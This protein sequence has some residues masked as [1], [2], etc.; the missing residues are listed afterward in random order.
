MYVIKYRANKGTVDIVVENDFRS[1]AI[2]RRAYDIRV[3]SC[4]LSFLCDA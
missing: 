3:Y 1:Q 2:L 4:R